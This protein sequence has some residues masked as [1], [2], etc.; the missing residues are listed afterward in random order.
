MV[1]NGEWIIKCGD[2]SLPLA[3]PYD[4]KLGTR[5]PCP[6]CGSSDRAFRWTGANAGHVLLSAK[7]RKQPGQRRS[8]AE[9][10]KGDVYSASR[11]KMIR[12]H[13]IIDRRRN[14]YFERVHD[15]DT[16]EVI[17]EVEQP[18]TEHRG[19]GDAKPDRQKP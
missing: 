7:V 8:P 16:R 18:L 10:I 1:E 19:H 13:R 2:C 14:L 17:G 9:E 4:M 5:P 11:G 15:P 3:E 12:I 6:E